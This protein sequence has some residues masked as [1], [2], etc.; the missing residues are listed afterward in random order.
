MAYV[1][2]LSLWHY[3]S[4]LLHPSWQKFGLAGLAHLGFALIFLGGAYLVLKL[5]DV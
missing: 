2:Y 3:S 1:R 4:D 5:R